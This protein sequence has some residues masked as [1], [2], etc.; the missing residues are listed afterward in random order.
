MPVVQAPIGPAATP[1]LV[2]A[3]SEA[4]GL[5]TLAASWTAP[6]ELRRQI[7]AI[8]GRVGRP[9]C[10]NLV[11]AF[12]QRER[13]EIALAEGAPAVSFSW[14]VDRE[15]IRL[16]HAAGS[17]VLV[18]VGTVA[19][20][21]SAAEA[22]ADCLLLQGTEA[23]GHLEGTAPTLAFV[24]EARRRLRIPLVAAGGISQPEAVTAALGAGA[25]AVACGTAFLAARE[26]NVHPMYLRRLVEA[27]AADTTLTTAFADGWPEAP[28]RVIRNETLERWEQAGRPSPGARPGDGETVAMRD[29]EPVARYSDAQPTRTTSGEI[30]SMA[31]YAGTSVSG[32]RMQEPATAIMLRLASAVA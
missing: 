20:A 15:L 32:V 4:G 29:G 18:Q 25:D 17:L 26:A 14:G 19:A 23:G 21:V 2:V 5:G 27:S 12:E 11:L 7:S 24:R 16:A 30:E 1:D 3:V 9:F 8:R 22:G 6:A 13:L 31:L 10:V 28:H